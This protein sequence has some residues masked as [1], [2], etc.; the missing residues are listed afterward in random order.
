MAELTLNDLSSQ[1]EID[2]ADFLDRVDL[3]CSLGQTV[4]IS[5][6]PEHYKLSTYLN[7]FTRNSQVAFILGIN[8]LALLFQE[9]YYKNLKGGILE[10]FGKLFLGNVKLLV[11]PSLNEDDGEE[12]KT[13]A[14]F[15]P[16][17]NIKHLYEHLHS[18]GCIQDI[19]NARVENLKIIS[20]NV[21]ALIRK[22]DTGWEKFVPHKVADI[23][24][25]Q[26]MFDYPCKV[27]E[28]SNP[29]D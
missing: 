10:A 18:N 21:L 27:K 13:C 2:E 22:G 8:N 3:L 4:L 11:Y 17:E 20:D 25:K 15:N 14:N 5:N 7:Q 1:G 26:C 16:A 12:L 6:Y 24:K 19:P 23:I 28:D 29:I 9:S